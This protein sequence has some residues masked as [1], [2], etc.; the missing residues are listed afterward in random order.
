M[1]TLRLV[2]TEVVKFPTPVVTVALEAIEGK[3]GAMTPEL[4]A[5]LSGVSIPLLSEL[6][7]LILE[8]IGESYNNGVQDS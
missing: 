5:A 2:G 7:C 8:A 1:R 4:R 3:L 6:G